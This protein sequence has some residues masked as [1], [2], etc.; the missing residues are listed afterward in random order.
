MR[1]KGNLRIPKDLLR[2]KWSREIKGDLVLGE[3]QTSRL[4]K[5][6]VKSRK[7]YQKD[8]YTTLPEIYQKWYC[9]REGN[10]WEEFNA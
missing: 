1:L 9:Q 3:L 2:T 8:E 7:Y 5:W 6:Q 4:L 10:S